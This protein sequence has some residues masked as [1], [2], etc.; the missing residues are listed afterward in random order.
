MIRR[1]PRSTLFPYTTLFRSHPAIQPVRP[2]WVTDV[3]PGELHAPR[4][5][6]DELPFSHV[7][8]DMRHARTRPGGEEQDVAGSERV[9]HGRDLRPGARLVGGRD[10]GGRAPT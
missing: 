4:R 7:Q 1:P 2:L 6:V 10:R 9:H 5:A 8:P 3:E